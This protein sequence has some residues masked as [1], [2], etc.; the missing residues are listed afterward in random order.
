MNRLVLIGNGFDIA[1]GLKTSYADLIIK[2]YRYRHL[3]YTNSKEISGD[4]FSVFGIP[5]VKIEK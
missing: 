2:G 3:F 4:T 5:F 1:H